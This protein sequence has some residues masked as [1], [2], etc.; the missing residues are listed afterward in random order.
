MNV[1]EEILALEQTRQ[2]IVGA[3]NEKG[4]EL[5]DNAPLN[6]VPQAIA[7]LPSGGGEYVAEGKFTLTSNTYRLSFVNPAGQIPVGIYVEYLGD[8]ADL[9]QARF[10][11]TPDQQGVGTLFEYVASSNNFTLHNIKLVDAMSGASA[12]FTLGANECV[13]RAR[14]GSRTWLAGEYR[15]KLMFEGAPNFNTKML[16]GEVTL[17]SETNTLYVYYTNNKTPIYAI[18]ELVDGTKEDN[19]SFGGLIVNAQ[20]TGQN[21]RSI[22]FQNTSGA[23]TSAVTFMNYGMGIYNNRIA[24]AGTR[25]YVVGKYRYKLFFEL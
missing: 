17:A 1:K 13:V 19:K 15:Y 8:K 25:N 18:I 4:G 10:V 6:A 22:F 20:N 24:F 5:A 16:E 23:L 14:A 9:C 11:Y 21:Y 3:V 12:E 2:N 7:D